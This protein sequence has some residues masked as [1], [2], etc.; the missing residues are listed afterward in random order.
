MCKDQKITRVEGAGRLRGRRRG[1]E[2]VARE[3]IAAAP[4]LPDAIAVW[5]IHALR[6]RRGR[7]LVHLAAANKTSALRSAFSVDSAFSAKRN[8]QF[9]ACT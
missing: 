5:I 8:A 9:F 2:A 4:L 3:R 6:R 7:H 1:R